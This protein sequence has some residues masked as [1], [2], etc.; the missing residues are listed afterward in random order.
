MGL[1][2]GLDYHALKG[3]SES[4]TRRKTTLQDPFLCTLQSNS[5][6]Q[7]SIVMSLEN[8]YSIKAGK[9]VVLSNSCPQPCCLNVI[10]MTNNSSCSFRDFANISVSHNT[11]DQQ[12][13]GS[14]KA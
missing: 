14:N 9:K 6:C 11:G 10:P 5:L 4:K 12:A 7:P 8:T 13:T 3:T 1:F 2:I